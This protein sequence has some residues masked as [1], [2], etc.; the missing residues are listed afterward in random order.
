MRNHNGTARSSPEGFEQV[1]SGIRSHFP[2][3]I[4]P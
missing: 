4:L 2:G 1:V 3:T